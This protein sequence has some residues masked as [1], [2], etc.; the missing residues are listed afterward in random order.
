MGVTVLMYHGIGVPPHAERTGGRYHIPA[1]ELDRH[2]ELLARAPVSVVTLEEALGG[3]EGVVLTFDDGEASCLEAAAA[4]AR[5][6]WRATMY[7]TT[8]FTG[9]PGYLTPPQLRELAGAGH[10]VGTHGD[11]HQFL[12]DLGDAALD[13]EVAGSRR[14]LEQILG[15]PVRHM[16][17]PGGRG[18]ARV[19]EVARR[20]GYAS[21]ATSRLGRN[22]RLDPFD[23][24]RV[25]I[26][27]GMPEG[28][29]GRI[30]RG[31]RLTFARDATVAG[32]LGLAKKTLGNQRYDR[33]RNKALSLIGKR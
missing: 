17:L 14:K 22:G 33:W 6:G 21:V 11:T 27:E 26:V 15:A 18:S 12:S 9:T 31:D 16:S 2:L 4:I 25:P 3:R 32:V 20:A 1:S 24:E 19:I 13:A 10:T 29:L 5:R 23:L 30:V 28:K 8:G 7:V